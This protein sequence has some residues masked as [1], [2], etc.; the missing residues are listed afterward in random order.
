[1]LVWL[2]ETIRPTRDVDLLGFG[3]VTQESLTRIFTDV[4]NVDVEPTWIPGGPW[5]ESSLH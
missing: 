2:G 3:E 5:V 1:M 4:C